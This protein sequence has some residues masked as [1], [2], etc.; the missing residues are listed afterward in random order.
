MFGPGTPD[1]G[2]PSF[3]CESD[4][5]KYST[6]ARVLVVGIASYLEGGKGMRT[7]SF[8]NYEWLVKSS[9]G[10]RVGPGGNLFSDAGNAVWVDDEA[11]L[12]LTIRCSQGAW[13]CTEVIAAPTMGF[14]RYRFRVERALAL[15]RNVVVGMFLYLDDQHEID[16]EISRFGRVH[17]PTNA[18]F[19]VQSPDRSS[20]GFVHRFTLPPGC[21]PSIH[22]I[23]WR[24]HVVHFRCL[25]Q[26]GNVLA[27][28]TT[29]RQV[30]DGALR[31]RINAWL[32]AGSGTQGVAPS[33][34]REVELVIGS[35]D[36]TSD[37]WGG[38]ISV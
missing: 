16:I 17:D 35:F 15:D 28:A 6:A 18:Q 2:C 1:N 19:A 26:A 3:V 30:P 14:G 34:G 32:Y 24:Q 22:E 9:G 27:S 23:E 4:S 21:A 37:P 7:L 20:D 31:A 33:D 13:H 29:T 5:W 8:A 11:R 12:H 10:A 36:F 38:R 25:T